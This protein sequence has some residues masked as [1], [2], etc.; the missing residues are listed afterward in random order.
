[1]GFVTEI[2]FSPDPS[3]QPQEVILSKKNYID[4][5]PFFSITTK[6]TYPLCKSIQGLHYIQK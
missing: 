4:H 6:L 2:D 1:M 3:K 5:P